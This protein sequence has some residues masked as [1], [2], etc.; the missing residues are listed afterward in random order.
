MT[1]IDVQKLNSLLDGE[2]SETETADLNEAL[3]NDAESAQR[4]AQLSKV[5]TL[6]RGAVGQL[7]LADNQDNT[8]SAQMA[9]MPGIAQPLPPSP[10]NAANDNW[11]RLPLTASVALV[12]GLFTG[13]TLFTG[14]ESIQEVSQLASFDGGSPVGNFLE[15]ASSGELQEIG[16][17]AAEVRLTF[18]G[19]DSNPCREFVLEGDGAASQFVACRSPDGAWETKLAAPA[20]VGLSDD[21]VGYQTASG[22]DEAFGLAVSAMMQSDAMDAQ[23]ESKL[24]EEGWKN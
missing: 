14:G 18:I 13:S 24:L 2:L 7:E 19:A 5:D 17:Y 12:V 9:R 20:P 16:S 4:L 1:R 21:A 15:T 10:V 6:L 3:I 8:L 22:G 23:S 11:W